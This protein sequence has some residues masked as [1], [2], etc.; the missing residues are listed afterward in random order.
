M[1]ES[2]VCFWIKF[3]VKGIERDLSLCVCVGGELKGEKKIKQQGCRLRANWAGK[4]K[5]EQ[6]DSYL[7]ALQRVSAGYTAV[8]PQSG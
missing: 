7:W 3:R 6:K 5:E 4:Q 2:V 8:Q 1:L